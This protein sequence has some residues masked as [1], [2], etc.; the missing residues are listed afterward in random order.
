MNLSRYGFS[1]RGSIIWRMIRIG[2]RENRLT[3]HFWRKS[4]NGTNDDTF[5][6]TTVAA[7]SK[8]PAKPERLTGLW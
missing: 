4:K 1:G 6:R 2:C 3:V 8:T 7:D 5:E